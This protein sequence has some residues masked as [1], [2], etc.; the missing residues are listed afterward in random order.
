MVE[1]DRGT[2]AERPDGPSGTQGRAP[3][4]FDEEIAVVHN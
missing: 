1:L 4:W 2:P 3:G